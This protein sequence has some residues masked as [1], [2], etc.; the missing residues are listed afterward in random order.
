MD[1]PNEIVASVDYENIGGT[2]VRMGCVT[3]GT[4]GVP[5]PFE[6]THYIRRDVHRNEIG[7]LQKRIELL[8]T[9]IAKA[10]ALAEVA[11]EC[12]LYVEELRCGENLSEALAAYREGKDDG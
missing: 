5:Q 6:P 12:H 9:Q 3:V 7:E 2:R 11:S 10:D 8:E 1:S 4:E